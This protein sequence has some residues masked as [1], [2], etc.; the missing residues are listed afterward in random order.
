MGEYSLM[1]LHW[2]SPQQ[3]IYNISLHAGLPEKAT[4]VSNN[5]ALSYLY[6]MEVSVFSHSCTLFP[7]H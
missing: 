4:S 7:A 1:N 5:T 3:Y 6:A 2:S